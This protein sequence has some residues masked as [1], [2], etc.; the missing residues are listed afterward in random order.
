LISLPAIVLT[1]HHHP[2]RLVAP[3]HTASPPRYPA[4]CLHSPTHVDIHST[5]PASCTTTATTAPHPLTSSSTPPRTT[6]A[7]FRHHARAL[8]NSST[9]H[10]PPLLRTRSCSYTYAHHALRAQ[11]APSA[12]SRTPPPPPP[13]IRCSTLVEERARALALF[14]PSARTPCCLSP[15]HSAPLSCTPSL[16]PPSRS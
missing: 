5:R 12:A 6:D 9:L 4:T 3:T 10:H 2:P 15:T 13:P 7:P 1:R 14:A 11:R 8:L 16:D